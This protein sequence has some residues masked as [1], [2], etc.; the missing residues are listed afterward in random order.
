MTEAEQEKMKAWVANWKLTGEE[1]D[2]L[3]WEELRAMDHQCAVLQ[4]TRALE[5]ADGWRAMQPQPVERSSGLI[6]QQFWFAKWPK[7]SI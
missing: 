4:S 6:E 2:R 7:Q 5:S 1:L 3:K